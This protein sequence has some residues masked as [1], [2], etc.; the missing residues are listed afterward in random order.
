M[1]RAFAVALLFISAP[2]VLYFGF[3]ELPQT[4]DESIPSCARIVHLAVAE[5]LIRRK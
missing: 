2:F 4:L 3:G 5:H 1:I